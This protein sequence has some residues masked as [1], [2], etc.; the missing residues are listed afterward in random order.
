MLVSVAVGLALAVA[1]HLLS[2]RL[3][4]WFSRYSAVL[5][6]LV[7]VAGFV[8]RLMVLGA[9]LVAIALWTSLNI[10][11][12]ALSFIGLFTVLTGFWLYRM[13]KK[14]GKTP[15]SADGTSQGSVGEA[16]AR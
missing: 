15:P 16:D 4:G 13:S 12:V 14:G 3:Q 6:P 2:V 1:Y 11:A 7:F 9:I 10:M 8:I 5:L